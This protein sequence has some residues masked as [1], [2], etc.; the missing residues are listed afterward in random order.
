MDFAL[1]GT[2]IEDESLGALVNCL[3]F[4]STAFTS[5]VKAKT[6]RKHFNQF[7]LKTL[8]FKFIPK[9]TDQISLKGLLLCFF[10][11]HLFRNPKN[12]KHTTIRNYVGNVR[13]VW[14]RQGCD[15]SPFDK[16][17]IARVLRGVRSLRPSEFDGR[18]PFLLPH[19]QFPSIFTQ[20]RSLDHLLFKAAVIFGFFGMF[21]FSSF[22]KI[23]I[24]NIVLVVDGREFILTRK[25]Y[26]LLHSSHLTGFYF[27]FSSKCHPNARA[28]YCALHRFSAPWATLCPVTILRHLGTNGLL[29]SGPLFPRTKLSSKSLG[30]YMTFLARSKHLFTPHSLRIGGHTFFSIQ[31]MHEDFVQ[32]LGRRSINKSSQLYY[33]ARAADNVLRLSMFF[34]R[35]S[36]NPVVNGRAL[37]GTH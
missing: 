17:V 29:F 33:R 19:F 4:N 25:H 11:A 27:S 16:Q 2:R 28:Y 13:A 32:F 18:V 1:F 9:T 6:G 34:H 30:S 3:F 31:N 15:L 37:F 10:V 7:I 21:R 5:R 23:R 20:P 8:G 36:Q 12:L 35:L 26:P 24:P 22:A 14:T